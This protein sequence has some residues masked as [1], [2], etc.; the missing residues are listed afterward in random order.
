MVVDLQKVLKENQKL[1]KAR[2]SKEKKV[3]VKKLVVRDVVKNPKASY[4]IPEKKVE[5]IFHDENRFFKGE[6]FND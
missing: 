3:L 1:K 2:Y 5:N 6:V 4:R